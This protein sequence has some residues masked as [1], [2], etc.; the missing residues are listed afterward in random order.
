MKLNQRQQDFVDAYILSGNA[1]EAARKA[2]YSE[3]T[4]ESQGSRLLKNAKVSDSIER[5]RKVAADKVD[6]SAA[7]ILRRLN[8][9]ADRCMQAE[10]VMKFDPVMGSM[11]HETTADGEGIFEFDSSGANR[12]LE[13][14]GKNQKLFTEKIEVSIDEALATRLEKAQQRVRKK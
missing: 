12:A 13:L 9:V 11:V 14:L 4:A 5:R 7:S 3:N 8:Q 2:G 6:I 1:T 10:P